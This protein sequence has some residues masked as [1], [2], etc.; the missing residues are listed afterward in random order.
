M[1]YASGMRIAGIVVGI[2]LAL[3]G[4]VW[5]LQGL[6]SQFVPVSFMTGS[7]TWIVIGAATFVGGA[8]LARWSWGQH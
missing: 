7:Q 2:V 3:M 1:T 4:A 5:L 6:N 8:V